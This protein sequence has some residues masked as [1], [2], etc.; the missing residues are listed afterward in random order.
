MDRT[1]GDGPQSSIKGNIFI[2]RMLALLARERVAQTARMSWPPASG[3][4][5][6]PDNIDAEF[7]PG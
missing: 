2:V 4:Q 1:A 3:R 7:Y 6:Y 5:L